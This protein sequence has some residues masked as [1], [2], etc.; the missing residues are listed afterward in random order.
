VLLA[1]RAEARPELLAIETRVEAG[2]GLDEIQADLNA[3]EADLDQAYANAERAANQEWND[4]QTNFQNMESSL[5]TNT[6]EALEFIG[7]AIS[8]LEED[9]RYDEDY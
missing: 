3:V 6:A 9:V 8:L 4:L 2:A 7:G 5:R 1:A